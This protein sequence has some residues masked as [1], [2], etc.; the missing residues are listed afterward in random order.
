LKQK[1]NR[2]G[3]P[4]RFSSTN[5]IEAKQKFPVQEKLLWGPQEFV[6]FRITECP[7]INYLG[8]PNDFLKFRITEWSKKITCFKQIIHLG[9]GGPNEF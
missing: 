4:K 2:F 5:F 8:G 3:G 7:R 9:G 1:K 6:K